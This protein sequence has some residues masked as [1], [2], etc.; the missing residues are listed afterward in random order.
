MQQ[1]FAF[2]KRSGT[3]TAS[4]KCL[5]L[6]FQGIYAPNSN[7]VTI[8]QVSLLIAIAFVAFAPGKISGET[9][10]NATTL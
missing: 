4:K 7:A 5:H 10:Q 3:I 9:N 1:F 2:E 6:F 8:D